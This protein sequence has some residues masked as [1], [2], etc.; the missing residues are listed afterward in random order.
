MLKRKRIQPAEDAISWVLSSRDKPCFIE[1]YI[2][3]NKGR[4]VFAT[5]PIE[6]G[7]FVLEYRGELLSVEDCRSRHY[8]EKQSTFLFEFL[9]QNRLWCIDASKEDGSLGRL[10]NDNQKSPNCT[11]KKVI[12]HDKPRLCLFAVKLI[13]A[14]TEIN[15]NYGNSKWPWR[16]KMTN[17][18]PPAVAVEETQIIQADPSSPGVSYTDSA[19][20]QVKEL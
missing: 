6:P 17:W 1:K 8:S 16:E 5:Q 12:V 19:N 4:G 20:S 3:S 9:W 14:G 7:A 11:I 2:D 18:Q 13:E 10:V 15:Y